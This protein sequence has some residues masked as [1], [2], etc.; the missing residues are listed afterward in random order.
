MEGSS[1]RSS[2]TP[3]ADVDGP[4]S[5]TPGPL[6]EADLPPHPTGTLVIVLGYGFLFAVFW[7]WVY[8]GEFLSRGI[9]NP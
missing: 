6:T 7:A 5:A 8:F 3:A 4:A 9:P 2:D 1:A